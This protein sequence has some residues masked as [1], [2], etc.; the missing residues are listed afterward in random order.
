MS[1]DNERTVRGPGRPEG[2]GKRG[3]TTYHGKCDVRLS[4]EEDNAL[5]RLAEKYETT[6]SEVM[7]K[8]LRDL[9]KWCGE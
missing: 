9:D 2:S 8:A 3:G 4:L 1:K 6:R 7:R 5:N